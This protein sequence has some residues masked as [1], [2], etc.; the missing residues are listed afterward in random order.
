MSI[1]HLRM[2]RKSLEDNHWVIDEEL[3]SNDCNVSAYGK[4]VVLM[5]KLHLV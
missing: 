4:L 3:P 1:E 2:L 5:A